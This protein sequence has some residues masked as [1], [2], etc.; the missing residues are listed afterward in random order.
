MPTHQA[1]QPQAAR[2][3]IKQCQPRQVTQTHLRAG[4]DSNTPWYLSTQQLCHSHSSLDAVLV[5]AVAGPG[6]SKVDTTSALDGWQT[7]LG[8]VRL[9]TEVTWNRLT[10][11]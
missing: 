2:S 9:K 1:T 11:S 10:V 4:R 3:P 7:G 6:T 8:I 5:E